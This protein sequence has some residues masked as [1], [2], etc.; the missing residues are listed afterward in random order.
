MHVLS[1]TPPVWQAGNQI[2]S[3]SVSPMGFRLTA[4]GLVG[5]SKARGQQTVNRLTVTV[6]LVGVVNSTADFIT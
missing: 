4:R 5:R 6:T 3:R 1:K 2:I